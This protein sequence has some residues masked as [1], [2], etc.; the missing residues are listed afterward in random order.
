MNEKKTNPNRDQEH[1]PQP[2]IPTR[3]ADLK[4]DTIAALLEPTTIPSPVD[5]KAL[6]L[7]PK[8]ENADLVEQMLL[9]VYRD[10]IFWRR[11]FH[12]EDRAVI[13]P[14]DR[15]SQS[16]EEFVS[17][18]QRELF[19]LLGE[20]KSDIPF[21]SP[22]YI[23]H[24]LADVS[25]PALV[26]YI[27]TMLYNPNNIAWEGSPVTTMIEIQVGR[28][29]AGMLGFGTTP[30][31]LALT[32]GHIT[33]GGTLA[34]MESIWIAKAVKF[35]ALAVRQAAIDLGV[36]GLAAGPADKSL[37]KITSWELVNLSPVEALDLKE[38]FI[39]RFVEQHPEMTADKALEQANEHL[40]QHSILSLGDHSFFSGLTGDH[41]L[42]PGVI[43]APQTKHY[44]WSKLPGAIGIGARKVVPIP[45]DA[46]YR[47]DTNQ[48]RQKLEWAMEERIPVIAVIAVVGATEEGAVDPVN[49]LVSLRQ[50][51]TARGLSF[52]IHCDAAYGGYLTTCFRSRD[53]KFRGLKEMQRE[54]AGWP[55]EDVYKSYLALKDVDSVTIDPHKLG[56]VPYPAGA[57]VFRDGRVKELVAQEAAY[58]L[59]SRKD[60]Q[61]SEIHIGK[62]ILEGSKP[63]AAAAA[64][65]LSHRVVPPDETG[66]GMVL[67]QTLCIARAF[68]DRFKEFAQTI[69]DE[70]ICR[71]LTSPDTNIVVYVFNPVGNDRL[72]LM[73]RFNQTLYREFSIDPSRPVQTRRFIVSH[74]DLSHELYNPAV[75]REF[76]EKMGVQR[77]YFVSSKELV[78]KQ[79]AGEVGYDDAVA[80]FRTTLMNPFTLEPAH[81]DKDYIHLFLETL[82]PLLRQVRQTL[83][84]R[85]PHRV[86]AKLENLSEIRSYVREQAAILDVDE[87]TTADMVLAVDEAATNVITHGYQDQE[88]V[89]EIEVRRE[90]DAFIVHLRDEAV[91]FDPTAVSSLD[92]TLPP[93]ER[94]LEGMGVGLMRRRT[95][96]IS[97]RVT[98][99]RGN[100][101]TLVKRGLK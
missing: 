18:F 100:E 13:L 2:D 96:E 5:L 52:Y 99:Q 22:R 12:P 98:L 46:K 72:D 53:G 41:A 27:A 33:S 56:Y 42:Q 39:L 55:Q 49:E 67:G 89:I 40:N 101:L 38:R 36:T 44:S 11:N 77:S 20:L 79:D 93:E 50:E 26:G 88:G 43:F 62:Y 60:P 9:N 94:I 92:L 25:L 34:N 81:G 90:G 76:L 86:V 64:T 28:E 30:E 97:H 47:M 74:T 63:G 66:Y 32:W 87:D 65:F 17:R 69:Q 10:Y 16:Y 82:E 3:S 84:I 91:P 4:K 78:Q 45:V 58:V 19:T 51:F 15:R 29:L 95:D 24:M 37:D 7:G 23:G 59:G 8:A 68:Q 35:L 70:F 1:Q 73:N 48:L 75:I 31:E 57:I 61:P 6:F 21:F 14:E 85:T 54:Y 83:E 71:L 80:V